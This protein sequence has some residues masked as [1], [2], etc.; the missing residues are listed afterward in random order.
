MGNEIYD[1]TEIRLNSAK[2]KYDLDSELL[3]SIDIAIECVRHE[4]AIKEIMM[5]PGSIACQKYEAIYQT[6]FNIKKG[7]Q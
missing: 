4:K 6:I 7:T 1:Y 3:A 2:K 5:Q